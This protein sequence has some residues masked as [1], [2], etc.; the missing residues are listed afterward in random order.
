MDS[1]HTPFSHKKTHPRQ[2]GIALD[3]WGRNLVTCCP[4]HA[5]EESS[6]FF[7]DALGY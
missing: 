7:Y 2:L 6:L 3:R 1:E 5:P 4:F